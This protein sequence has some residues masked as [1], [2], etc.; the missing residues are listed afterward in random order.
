MRWKLPLIK[1]IVLRGYVRQGPHSSGNDQV[2]AQEYMQWAR[3]L[4][5]VGGIQGSPAGEGP[6][7]M[8]LNQGR[9]VQHKTRLIS[10]LSLVEPRHARTLP[11][12]FSPHNCRMQPL[13]VTTSTRYL[14]DTL[15]ISTQTSNTESSVLRNTGP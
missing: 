11:F 3:S 12:S 8:I 7:M 5:D 9:V 15:H 10:R 14:E 6:E 13:V 2:L 4:S 1:M